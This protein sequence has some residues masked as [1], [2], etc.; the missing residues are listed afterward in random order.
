MTWD[1][2]RMGKRSQINVCG[3]VFRLERTVEDRDWRFFI[4]CSVYR[5]HLDHQGICICRA[6][7]PQHDR[8]TLLGSSNRGSHVFQSLARD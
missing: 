4:V 5:L 3:R 8:V 6:L 2:T 7:V 1:H